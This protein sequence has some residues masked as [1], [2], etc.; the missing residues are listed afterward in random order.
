MFCCISLSSQNSKIDHVTFKSP[1]TTGGTTYGAY[2]NGYNKDNCAIIAAMS[3]HN[4]MWCD[5]FGTFFGCSLTSSGIS[6]YAVQ[7][8]RLGDNIRVSLLK[9]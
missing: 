2:P 9:L 8:G 5:E 3:N 4:G 1:T 7:A 6:C